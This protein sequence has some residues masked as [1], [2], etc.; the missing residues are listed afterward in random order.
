MDIT[1][2][3]YQNLNLT[4]VFSIHRPN[5]QLCRRQGQMNMTVTWQYP[6]SVNHYVGS[7]E[8]YQSRAD[9][10]RTTEA[11]WKKA[12]VADGKDDDWMDTWLESFLAEHG[13]QKALT[14]LEEYKDEIL[15]QHQR[16]MAKNSKV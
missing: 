8:R 15:V 3:T 2:F 7:L 5:I 4:K 11:Y 6:I 10:R 9:P 13:M 16:W 1:G 14:V 12:R